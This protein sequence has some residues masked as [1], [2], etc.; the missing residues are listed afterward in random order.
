VTVEPETEQ[1]FAASGELAGP[2]ITEPSFAL[3]C[4]PWHGHWMTFFC[5]LITVQPEWVQTAVKAL[6]SPEL[7]WV[8][9]TRLSESM[10]PPSTGTLE[11]A[12]VFEPPPA[13][14]AV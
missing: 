8:T 13:A 7:G 14:A 2:W 9:T 11:V 5:T 3:N 1:G 12:T 4:E 6:Y 10:Y